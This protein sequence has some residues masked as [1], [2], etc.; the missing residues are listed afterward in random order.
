MHSFFGLIQS[1]NVISAL[2]LIDFILLCVIHFVAVD[3]SLSRI[4]CWTGCIVIRLICFAL[5]VLLRL[6][7][8]AEKFLQFSFYSILLVVSIQITQCR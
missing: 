5:S 8:L 4:D 6:M 2:Y 7:Y 3:Q 1:G